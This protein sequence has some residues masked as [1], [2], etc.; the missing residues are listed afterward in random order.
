MEEIQQALSDL[1]D[2][3]EPYVS[4]ILYELYAHAEDD[5]KGL[6]LE[7]LTVEQRWA[8]IT[9]WFIHGGQEMVLSEYVLANLDQ[10]A[11]FL[12]GVKENQWLN[13]QTYSVIVNAYFNMLRHQCQKKQGNNELA[14][15]CEVFQ[16]EVLNYKK[17]FG[18]N[19][20]IERKLKNKFLSL[21]AK[22][23]AIQV[24]GLNAAQ[25]GFLKNMIQECDRRK[26]FPKD[27]KRLNVLWCI[28][29]SQ[30]ME[31]LEKM[32]NIIL[33]NQDIS[34][35]LTPVDERLKREEQ[36]QSIVT[37]LPCSRSS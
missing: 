7:Q 23:N 21:I 22:M 35:Y 5:R 16:D 28:Y 31:N 33:K 18:E 4:M 12:S 34:A 29:Y 6:L 11:V 3:P 26:I 36:G 1:A 30:D 13:E 37:F 17:I 24:F 9:E 32:Q 14:A 20:G 8:I 2:C 25:V 15:W 19:S 27:W 10:T